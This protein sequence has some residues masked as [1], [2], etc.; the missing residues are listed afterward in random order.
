V[1]DEHPA[2]EE[3]Q[4]RGGDAVER[5]RERDVGRRD[6]VH[7]LRTEVTLGVDEG[8]PLVLDPARGV[9]QDDRHLGDPV[10]EARGE[11]RGLEV[12]D[13]ESGHA[14]SLPDAA[15]VPAHPPTSRTT[16]RRGFAPGRGG[17]RSRA[18][19]P[20]AASR[21]VCDSAVPRHDRGRSAGAT[22]E[23]DA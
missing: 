16:R 15:H 18:H 13:G 17:L 9:D 5:R 7:V 8:A 14:H 4:E 20:F 6:A 23:E 19:E 21:L 10:A 11:P 3:P 12:D 2:L 1:R 22:V